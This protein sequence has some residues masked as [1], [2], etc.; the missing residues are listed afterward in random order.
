M[1]TVEMLATVELPQAEIDRLAK[2]LPTGRQADGSESVI[3]FDNNG[4]VSITLSSWVEEYQSYRIWLIIVAQPNP[5]PPK[6]KRKP[7]TYIAITSINPQTSGW[8]VMAAGHD[9]TLV[10]DYAY[11]LLT[12]NDICTDTKRIN[13]KVVSVSHAKRAYGFDWGCWLPDPDVDKT[14]K[15]FA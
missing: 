11:S 10:G 1:K 9:K 12:G 7:A 2:L 14:Y 6:R 4:V 13:L 8:Q 5:T 3:T 15:W